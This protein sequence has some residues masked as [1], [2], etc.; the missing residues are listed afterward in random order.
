MK[1]PAAW[2]AGLFENG[3]TFAP[4]D[5]GLARRSKPA[6]RTGGADPSY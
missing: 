1:N 5:E 3:Q 6:F 2:G 4:E